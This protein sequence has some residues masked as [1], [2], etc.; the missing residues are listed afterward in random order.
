MKDE[1]EFKAW[2]FY[3]FENGEKDHAD[4]MAVIFRDYV[5]VKDRNDIYSF[6]KALKEQYIKGYPK[7]TFQ[8]YQIDSKKVNLG[9]SYDN[10]GGTLYT[11]TIYSKDCVYN[12]YRYRFSTNIFLF[13]SSL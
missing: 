3:N 10:I 4:T 8:P 6:Y 12:T 2:V 5:D 11:L 1:K 13:N 9:T 7:I